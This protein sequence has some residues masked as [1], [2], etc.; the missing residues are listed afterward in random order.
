MDRCAGRH[1]TDR[2]QGRYSMS[3]SI[4]TLSVVVIADA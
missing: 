2:E 4:I 1:G 3:L